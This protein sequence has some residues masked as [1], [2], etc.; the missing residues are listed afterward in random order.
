[1]LLILW[2]FYI[3]NHVICKQRQFHVFLQT[4]ITFILFLV[5]LHHYNFH[6]DVENEWWEGTSS[7]SSSYWVRASNFSQLSM[8]VV[9]FLFRCSLSSWG[10]SPLFLV[11]QFC[12]HEWMLDFVKFFVPLLIWS[13]DF[14]SLALLMWWITLIYS[15][16]WT[17]LAYF[18]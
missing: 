5:L 15:K 4:G 3:D 7:P 1:M 17:S 14:S 10:N 18:G 9:G 12:D 16:C 6:Y 13:C 2:I 11:C 8:L